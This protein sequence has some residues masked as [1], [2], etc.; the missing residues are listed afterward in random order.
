[1]AEDGQTRG[2]TRPRGGR[3]AEGL[4]RALEAYAQELGYSVRAL[5]LW[6]K[7]G[8]EAEPPDPCPLDN[9]AQL[10]AWWSRRMKQKV[11][12]RIVEAAAK[13]SGQAVVAGLPL[14]AEP[15][16]VDHPEEAKD[17]QRAVVV[18]EAEVGLSASLDRIR[19]AEAV[20]SRAYLEAVEQKLDAGVI[21]QRQRAWERTL[22]A[23]RKI[24]KDGAEL[25]KTTGEL[26]RKSDLKAVLLPIHRALATGVRSFLRRMRPKLE[27]LNP[28]EQ[29]KVWAQETEALFRKMNECQFTGPIDA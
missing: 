9:Y 2:G 11:P 7:I 19:R 12:T 6:R 28:T 22:E 4:S 13:A 25:L 20:A 10:P 8:N 29:D 1:M 27:G 15:P 5:K 23:L 18:E 3:R 24:E 16:K 26:V 21:E 14:F 17:V